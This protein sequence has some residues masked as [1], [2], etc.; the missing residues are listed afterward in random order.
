MPSLIIHTNVAVS[1]K[2]SDP[3]AFLSRCSSATAAMLGKPESYVMVELCDNRP[4]LFGGTDAPLAFVELKSLGLNAEQTVEL[5]ARLCELLNDALAI[6]P[7]RVYI[8][9]AAPERAMF[10]WN[11]STF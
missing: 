3:S 5:S 11:G 10:G 9:F 2:I 4:M 6:D 1:D 7:A 8:E